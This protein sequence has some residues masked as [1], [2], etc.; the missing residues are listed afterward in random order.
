M[1]SGDG[2]LSRSLSGAVDLKFWKLEAIGNDFP[3][4]HLADVDAS[5][6]PQL[7][8]QLCDR[9]FGVGGDGLL[10][11]G[12]EED[13]LR[14]RMFNPDGTE[15]FCG[16]GLRCAAIHAHSQNWVGDRFLIRHH[17]RDVPAVIKGGNVKTTLGVA[18]YDPALVPVNFES[19]PANSFDRIVWTDGSTVVSG[20]VLSTGTTHTII[21]GPLPDDHKFHSLSPRIETALQFPDRTSIMWA[22][23]VAPMVLKLRIWERGV[24]ETLGCGSGST[25]AAVD[26][27]RRVGHGGTV[28]VINPGGTVWVSASA[29]NEPV[30]LKGG[31]NE[32]FEGV[33]RSN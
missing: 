23:T 18:T 11:V 12:M 5:T 32:V 33:V 4:L 2:E 6:L 16:N 10:A 9:R 14:L 20:S 19:E 13:D 24:G 29:W 15:D 8:I 7:A 3:L 25:A 31:A 26:Y 21:P 30:T 17:G 27:L 1:V 28:E 22:E